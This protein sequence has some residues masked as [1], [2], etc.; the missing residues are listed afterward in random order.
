MDNQ[1]GTGEERVDHERVA[2]SM[3]EIADRSQRLVQDFL[4]HQADKGVPEPDPLNIGGA[5]LEMTARMM[6]N[7]AHLIEANLGLWK[8][9]MALWHH[10][11]SRM[12]GGTPER[13]A[14]PE[15]GDR[16]FKDKAWI[17]NDV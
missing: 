8:D 11:A 6:A 12:F 13:V 7:P 17:E 4:A 1:P 2:H 9:Y 3:A 15:P 14:Q 10:A 5:F 16:R